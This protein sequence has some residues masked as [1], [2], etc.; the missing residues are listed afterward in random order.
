MKKSYVRYVATGEDIMNGRMY[1]ERSLTET[2][3]IRRIAV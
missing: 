3:I 1:D 2:R